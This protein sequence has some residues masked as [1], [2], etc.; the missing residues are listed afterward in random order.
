[1][2][3]TLVTA[4]TL[5]L[6]GVAPIVAA[7]AS[8]APPAVNATTQLP[9]N[10]RPTHYE[11]AVVP[12]AES[13]NFDGHVAITLEVL[14]PTASITLNAVDMT[15]ANSWLAAAETA[16]AIP[17]TP[18]VSIDATAQ[19]ATFTFAKPL[20]PGRYTLTTDYTGKIGTQ[21][22]GLFAIDYDTRAGKKRALYTQFENSDARKFIPS[23]DE[24]NYKA[25]F[26]LTATVP[27]AQMAVSN[28]PAAETTD[29]GNGSKRVRFAQSPKMSTYLLFFGLGDFERATLQADGT[30]VGVVTQTGMIDQAKFALESSVGVLREYNDYFGVKYP[31]PKL[32]NI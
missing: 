7:Q 8:V 27:S 16:R 3:R 15:F 18:K 13:M 4:I 6:A 32:D 30:E 12:H 24:P 19:T 21:A 17:L 26:D 29:L 31:L 28:M 5:A 1:M 25:T 23:W 2:R 14:E 11:V 22:N 20:T 10:V 9:R